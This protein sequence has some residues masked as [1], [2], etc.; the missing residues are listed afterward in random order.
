[1]AVGE[2]SG[3]D[4]IEVQLSLTTGV[5]P[6][7]GTVTEAGST[8]RPFHGW[9]EL[10]DALEQSRSGTVAAEGFWELPPLADA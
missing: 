1:V 8:P 4:A 7:A 10:M 5:G 9:L 3:T 2:S 6:V